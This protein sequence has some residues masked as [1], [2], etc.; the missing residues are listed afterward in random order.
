MAEYVQLPSDSS[1]TGK[2][3]WHQTIAGQGPGGSPIYAEVGASIPNNAVG[4]QLNDVPFQAIPSGEGLQSVLDQTAALE[5]LVIVNDSGQDGWV[6]V[7]TG[8]G[9]T[10]MSA[11]NNPIPPGTF[12]IPLGCLTCTNGIQ[13]EASGPGFSGAMRCYTAS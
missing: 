4:I 9:N 2:A 12:S 11:T 5:I 6:S 8:N 10:I 3:I 13:W 7:K 1:N